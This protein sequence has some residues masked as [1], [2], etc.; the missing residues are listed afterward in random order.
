MSVCRPTDGAAW[1]EAKRAELE[2]FAASNGWATADDHA[3]GEVLDYRPYDERSEIFTVAPEGER[4]PIG[5]ARLIWGSAEQGLDGFMTPKVHELDPEWRWFLEQ[6]GP[7]RIGE[8]GTLGV[9]TNDGE[10]LLALCSAMYRMSRA[11]RVDYWLQSVTR[12]VFVGLRRRFRTPM[13]RIGADAVVVG[14]LSIP[15][16]QSLEEMASGRMLA[17]DPVLKRRMFG[18][19]VDRPRVDDPLF[20]NLADNTV[21]LTD[22]APAGALVV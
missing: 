2:I 15:T 7:T 3:A 21:D 14:A 13:V 6:I 22:R 10:P 1:D 9:T 17:W 4:T 18:A 11:R 5:V 19:W 20:I 16:L 8:W 12:P